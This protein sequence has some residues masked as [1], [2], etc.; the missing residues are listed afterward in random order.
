MRIVVKQSLFLML[1]IFILLMGCAKP[2]S[3]MSQSGFL[4]DYSKL[5]PGGEERAE[6][7]YIKDGVDFTQYKTAKMD[8]VVFYLAEDAKAQGV[9]PDELTEL[10]RAFEEELAIEVNSSFPLVDTASPETLRIRIAVTDIKP[11]NPVRNTMGAI[12]PVGWVMTATSKARKSPPPNVGRASIEME[13]L[14]SMSGEVLAAAID[15][16]AGAKYDLRGGTTK[17]GHVKQAFKEW[18]YQLRERL[19]EIHAKRK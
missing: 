10:S 18:A 11:A 16:K 19:D 17:W 1:F 6:Y 2:P 4:K 3:E 8:R 7:I 9:L 13:V 14:D 5:K 12:M 15:S